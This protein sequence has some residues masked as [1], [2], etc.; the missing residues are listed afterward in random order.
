V[1]QNDPTT[2]PA[3]QLKSGPRLD[4]DGPGGGAPGVVWENPLRADVDK[5]AGLV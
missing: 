4:V 3:P 5:E 2:E 1:I